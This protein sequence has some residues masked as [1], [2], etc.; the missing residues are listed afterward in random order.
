MIVTIIWFRTLYL[1]VRGRNSPISCLE[2]VLSNRTGGLRRR[3]ARNRYSAWRSFTFLSMA[4][5]S[6]SKPSRLIT[7]EKSARHFA[8]SLMV[9]RR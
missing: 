1:G 3:A 8:S 7:D 5:I 2:R 6:P 9:P 4:A